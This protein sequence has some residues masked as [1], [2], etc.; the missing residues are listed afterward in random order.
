M[1]RVFLIG[2]LLTGLVA[3]GTV[4][5]LEAAPVF[6]SSCQ[7]VEPIAPFDDAPYWICTN[8]GSAFGCRAAEDSCV[9]T[10]DSCG[11]IG[12]FGCALPRMVSQPVQMTLNADTVKTLKSN[13]DFRV[14]LVGELFG[15]LNLSP[16]FVWR[17]PV[18]VNIE[19]AGR[20]KDMPDSNAGAGDI[21][22]LLRS[23]KLVRG[24]QALSH[25]KGH[26]TITLVLRAIDGE[27]TGSFEQPG[28]LVTDRVGEFKLTVVGLKSLE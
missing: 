19:L 5:I 6:C 25:M 1:R 24:K 7:K 13:E 12:G 23:G 16:D 21:V 3:V 11:R 4:P 14:A 20:K 17:S 9:S 18:R 22:E 10:G 2:A 8:S 15:M 27:V 26:F 28:C